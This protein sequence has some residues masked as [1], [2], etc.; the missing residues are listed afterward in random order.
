MRILYQYMPKIYDAITFPKVF[1]NGND[2]P[3]YRQQL[4]DFEQQFRGHMWD[5]MMRLVSEMQKARL[6]GQV[7]YTAIPGWLHKWNKEREDRA[8][9]A[10]IN[11]AWKA[12]RRGEPEQSKG[13][14]SPLPQWKGY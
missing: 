1:P 12:A 4:V 11:T 2:V 10:G 6:A 7:P 8:E 3:K 13:E 5:Y 14:S 9:L